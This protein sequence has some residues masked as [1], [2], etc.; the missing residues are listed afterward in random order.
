LLKSHCVGL[1]SVIFADDIEICSQPKALG[2]RSQQQGIDLPKTPHI[3][4]L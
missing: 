1:C 4:A 2:P 3:G